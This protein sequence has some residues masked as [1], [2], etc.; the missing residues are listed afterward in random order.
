M[1]LMSSPLYVV[2][3]PNVSYFL[4]WLAVHDVGGI[5]K[6]SFEIDHCYVMRVRFGGITSGLTFL[7]D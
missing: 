5:E 2:S 1:K 7:V 3:A 6:V 4:Q